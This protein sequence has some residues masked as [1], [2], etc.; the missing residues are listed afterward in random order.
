MA[1][2]N[3]LYRKGNRYYADLRDYAAVGGGKEALKPPGQRMATTD[4]DEAAQLLAARLRQL[5]ELTDRKRSKALVGIHRQSG[6]AAYADRHLRMK[7]E[8]GE[9]VPEW[10]AQAQRHL[11]TAATY[12][13]ADCDLAAI[14][15]HDMGRYVAYLRQLANGRGGTFSDTTV[16]KHLNSLSNMYKRALSE[17]Y[18]KQNPVADM[19]SKPTE[20]K[21]EAEYLEPHEAALLLEAA[22]TYRPAVDPIRQ[23]HGGAITIK[24][25]PWVYPIIATCLLTGGRKSE[26]LGLEVDDVSFRLGK[27]YIRSNRWRRLKTKGSKRTIPLWPQ[28]REI[29]EAYMLER[30]RTGGLGSLLFPSSRGDDESMVRDLHKALDKI[31]ARA[32]FPAGHIR[33]HMLR[34]TYTAA[35]IQTLDRGAPIALYS[36]ARELGHSSTDMIE[37]RYGHLHDRAVAGG[38]DVVEFRVEQHRERLANQLE[39][40]AA[41]ELQSSLSQSSDRPKNGNRPAP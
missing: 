31:G 9:A 26:V 37:D 40:L 35:R 39:T 16:R 29:L 24:P 3:R 1:R 28:L 27:I 32:G 4:A 23:Q 12:F 38:A 20:R 2:R 25:N 34:H 21:V 6:L 5:Q 8:D 11:E 22:R 7:A 18:V 13:G 36:V 15:T 10:L 30:E 17:G 41:P 33:L 19:Y 14:T